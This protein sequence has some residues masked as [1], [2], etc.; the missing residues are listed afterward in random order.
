MANPVDRLRT[1]DLAILLCDH[2][3]TSATLLE[4]GMLLGDTQSRLASAGALAGV[5][6]QRLDPET[7]FVSMDATP[8]KPEAPE[9]G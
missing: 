9:Y 1:L 5:I 7:T 8:T 6:V 4:H 3:L 2:L